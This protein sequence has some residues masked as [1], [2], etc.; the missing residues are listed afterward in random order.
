M[1][2]RQLRGNR[3]R[4]GFHQS[5]CHHDHQN[6]QYYVVT[7][8]TKVS[9]YPNESIIASVYQGLKNI[10]AL[11]EKQRGFINIRTIK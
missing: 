4:G 10:Q 8:S 11:R 2:A 5:H 3:L 9:K 7:C 6:I 1:T